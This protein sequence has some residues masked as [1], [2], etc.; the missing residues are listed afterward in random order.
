M[1]NTFKYT[2]KTLK[3]FT[4]FEKKLI[5]FYFQTYKAPIRFFFFWLSFFFFNNINII[6]NFFKKQHFK[7]NTNHVFF[8]TNKVLNSLILQS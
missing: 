8:I 1:N 3:I 7:V 5:L 6:P 2:L 4:L